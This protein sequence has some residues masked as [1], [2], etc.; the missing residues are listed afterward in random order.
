MSKESVNTEGQ[1][2]DYLNLSKIN[3]ETDNH[4]TGKFDIKCLGCGKE[5]K[6]L[7]THLKK[8]KFCES[9]YDIT[10]LESESKK[11]RLEKRRLLMANLRINQSEEDKKKSKEV[12]KE[13]M[14]NFRKSQPE[15]DKKK[16]KEVNKESKAN[17]RKSQSEEDKKKS[18]EV[19]KESMANFR[20]SQ[21][22]EDKRVHGQYSIKVNRNS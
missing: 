22:E 20:K 14:A 3:K 10:S 16:S 12:H 18:K 8:S 15:E 11:L 2:Q 9:F 4:T 7:L 19:H 21:S 6:R 5:F 13:S 17:F 1:S